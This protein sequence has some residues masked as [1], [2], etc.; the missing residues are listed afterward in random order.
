MGERCC[1]RDGETGDRSLSRY[2]HDT[3]AMDDRLASLSETTVQ[4]S[5]IFLRMKHLDNLIWNTLTKGSKGVYLI[6]YLAAVR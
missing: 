5:V 1:K 4:R 3:V 2:E 6:W